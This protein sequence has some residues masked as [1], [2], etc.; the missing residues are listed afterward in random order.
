MKIALDAAR[1]LA[2]LHEDSQPCVIHRDFK[3][4]NILLE[5][6]FHA[7]VAD[8]GLAKQAPEGRANYLSTRVMGTFGLVSISSILS[9]SFLSFGMALRCNYL[10]L[11]VRSSRVR[12]DWTPTC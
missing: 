8:F 12:H 11:Q 9:L 3:A 4:S 2:Y 6:N 7:K 10:I 1:G 5:N